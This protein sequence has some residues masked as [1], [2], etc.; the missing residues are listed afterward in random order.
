MVFFPPHHVLKGVPASPKHPDLLCS[1]GGGSRREELL[2]E[3]FLFLPQTSAL[4]TADETP[5]C[6]Q[7]ITQ[8][9]SETESGFAARRRRI[10]ILKLTDKQTASNVK[11][12]QLRGNV[13][14]FTGEF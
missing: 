4:L 10:F 8:F 1:Q 12:H 3:T 9:V 14:K 6:L 5:A 11:F 2:A 13:K 7:Q